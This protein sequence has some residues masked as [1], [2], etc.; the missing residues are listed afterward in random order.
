MSE[1]KFTASKMM[2]KT[3]RNIN[4]ETMMAPILKMNFFAELTP[5]KSN[6]VRRLSEK[7]T[8]KIPFDVTANNR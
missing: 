7:S 1:M 4:A 6:Q 3:H 5:K 8:F 2:N